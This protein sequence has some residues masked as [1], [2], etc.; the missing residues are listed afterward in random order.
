MQ[1]TN[2]SVIIEVATGK[3]VP[4][5]LDGVTELCVSTRVLE[6]GVVVVCDDVVDAVY[7][8]V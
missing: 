7:L 4:N 5:P 3:G 2:G 6:S 1:A 8:C